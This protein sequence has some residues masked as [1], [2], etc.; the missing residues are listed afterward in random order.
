MRRKSPPVPER[1]NAAGVRL[2]VLRKEEG[3]RQSDVVARLQRKG[4]KAISEPLL[5][6]IERGKRGLSDIELQ[7]IL[8][9]L[10]KNWSDLE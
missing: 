8:R 7:L 6:M 4:W 10:G 3:L 9:A 2:A 5:S 1:L